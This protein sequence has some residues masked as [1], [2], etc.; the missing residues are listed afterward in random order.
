MPRGPNNVIEFRIGN[1]LMLELLTPD[2]ARDY[3][4][5]MR[6][7]QAPVKPRTGPATAV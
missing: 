7:F 6:R 3:V 5:A 2:M 1:A 4:N